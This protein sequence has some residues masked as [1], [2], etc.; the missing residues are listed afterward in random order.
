M[1]ERKRKR[2]GA[3]GTDLLGFR[4]CSRVDGVQ[5][6]GG[7]GSDDLTFL[8]SAMEKKRGKKRRRG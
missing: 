1:T 8:S 3:S 6:F 5:D 7:S 2:K 4:L